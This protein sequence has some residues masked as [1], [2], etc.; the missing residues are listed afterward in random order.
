MPPF[1]EM[2]RYQPAVL[3]EADGFDAYGQP[4]ADRASPV[5]L[6]VRWNFKRSEAPG[7]DSTDIL[8]DATV[9][10][11]RVIKVGS[12]MWPG[13]LSDYY[14]T[15]SGSG[16]DDSSDV[17]RVVFCNRTLDLKGGRSTR[18]DVGLQKFRGDAGETS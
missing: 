10:A 14:G 13:G 7:P 18:Y 2:D 3:W 9:V 15:G 4:T 6:E 5:E 12:R 16:L 11:D 17:Y 1:E 8:L